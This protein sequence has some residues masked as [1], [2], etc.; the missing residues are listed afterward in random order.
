MNTEKYRALLS[1]IEKG[2]LSAAGEELGYT[3]SGMSRLIA[4]LEEEIGLPL[5]IR[6]RNGA[7]A[8]RDCKEL[9]PYFSRVVLAEKELCKQ[10]EQIRGLDTGHISIGN[11]YSFYYDWLAETVSE[12]CR[13]YPAIGVTVTDGASSELVQMIK[14]YRLDMAIVSRRDDL[15]L[16]IPLKED[17]L[18][19]MVPD[20]HRAAAD[21]RFAA[22]D[23]T[24]EHF[25][26]IFPGKE[27][28]ESIFF[29]ENNIKVKVS[30]CVQDN[31]AA[32]S[33]VKAGLGIA[34]INETELA[35]CRREGITAVPLYP[36]KNVQ[37]GIAAGKGDT[38]SFALKKFLMFMEPRIKHAGIS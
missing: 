30:H 22:G 31:M 35:M 14:D 37:L 32:A 4:S 18:M 8:T 25:I 5:L 15:P 7:E 6:G 34:M 29:R 20:G 23:L 3:P 10:T 33:M 28:D 9:L 2:S 26:E 24:K 38:A 21:G 17:R 36:E 1:A 11:A 13:M 27:T 12:F 19:V 16:W